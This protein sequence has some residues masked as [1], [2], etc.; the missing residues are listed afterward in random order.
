MLVYQ[1]Q[2]NPDDELIIPENT[3]FSKGLLYEKSKLKENQK[4]IKN[5]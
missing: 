2:E 5:Q 3:N 4:L 1:E